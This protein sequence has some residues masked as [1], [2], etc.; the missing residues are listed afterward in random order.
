M[1]QSTQDILYHLR[2][3]QHERREFV[4]LLARN[5]CNELRIKNGRELV[6]YIGFGYEQSNLEA[7]ET[8]VYQMCTDMKLP[9]H[10]S[11]QEMLTCILADVIGC[12]CEQENLNIFCRD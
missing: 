4:G 6:P 9:F 5:L 10:S 2:V 3:I 1:P 11:Q 7:I 8:W 12:I